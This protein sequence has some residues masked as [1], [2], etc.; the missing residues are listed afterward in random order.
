MIYIAI[1]TDKP[2]AELYILKDTDIISKTVWLAHRQLLETINIKI[3]EL[4]KREKLII[5]DVN[6]L[7]F[8]EGPGS[9]TGLRIGASVANAIAAGLGVPIVSSGHGDWL[10]AG[11]LSLQDTQNLG[12][13][14]PKYGSPAHVTA[15]K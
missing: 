2:E 5:T 13:I 1:R 10:Q 12:Y 15:P 11:V 9:F 3:D 8:Y 7:V 4:L 6:G 14:E